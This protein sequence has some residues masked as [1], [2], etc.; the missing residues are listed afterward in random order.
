MTARTRALRIVGRVQEK[1][2]GDLLLLDLRKSS[3]VSDFFVICTAKSPLHA[4]AIADEV[5]LK[6]KQEG[7]PADHVEGYESGQWILID[8]MDVLVHIFLADMRQFFGLERLWGDMP[9][10]RFDEVKT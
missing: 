9:A 7:S 1:K 10:K 6:L 5:L 8:F 2:G 4:R 3:P